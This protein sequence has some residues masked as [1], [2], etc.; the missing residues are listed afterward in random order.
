MPEEARAEVELVG[1][2]LVE[3]LVD[4]DL[5]ADVEVVEEPEPEPDPLPLLLLLA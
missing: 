4:E 5:T 1:D 3:E 2:L